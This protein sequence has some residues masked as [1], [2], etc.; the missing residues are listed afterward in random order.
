MHKKKNQK[1]TLNHVAQ[2]LADTSPTKKSKPTQAP[3]KQQKEEPDEAT[4]GYI[5]GRF[6]EILTVYFRAQFTHNRNKI[7]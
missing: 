1:P 4:K 7:I 3:P 2:K 6:T 5:T